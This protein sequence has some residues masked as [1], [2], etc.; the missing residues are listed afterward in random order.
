[1]DCTTIGGELTVGRIGLGATGTVGAHFLGPPADPDAA[2]AV[3]RRAPG[4]G[5]KLIDTADAYGPHLSEELIADA[6]HPY[7]STVVVATKGGSVRPPGSTVWRHAGARED[8]RAACEGSLRRLRLE[9]L[10]LYQLHAPDEDVPFAES[11]GALRELRD[12]GK[13]RHI[14]ISNV[15]VEQLEEARRI[16]DVATV[17]NRYSVARRESEDVVEACER[18][19][20]VFLAYSPVAEGRLPSSGTALRDVVGELGAAPSQVAL[21]WLLRRSPVI[22]PIPGTGSLEHLADNMAAAD[23]RISDQ[24]YDRLSTVWSPEGPTGAGP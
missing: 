7:P 16:V 17:Q 19:G 10:P 22:V 2:R 15:T 20:I 3:L 4:L 13:V 5:V 9:V 23:L 8:L 18:L 11:I 6:L 14:G 21:A 12:E 1:M 24:Q